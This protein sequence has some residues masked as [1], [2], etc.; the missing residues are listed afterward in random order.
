MRNKQDEYYDFGYKYFGP[1]LYGFVRWLKKELKDQGY[2]KVFF[3]SR[4]GYMMKK[5]F[6]LVNDT[7]IESHYVY[8]S[9][10]SLRIPLLNIC[11]T[12]EESLEFLSW[13]RFISIKELMSY[14]GLNKENSDIIIPKDA[15]RDRTVSFEELKS[16]R[17]FRKIFEENKEIIKD[18][19]ARQ[20][21]YLLKYTEQCGMRNRFAI[22]DIG[23]Q[24]AV[25]S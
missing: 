15:E 24:Y 8:F 1:F 5:A 3:F 19:S 22:V 16:D 25:L 2:N 6:D 18:N 12:Y 17:I 20:E 10:R 7:D 23:W 4:D 14:Y 11:N 9:R 13:K 21:E